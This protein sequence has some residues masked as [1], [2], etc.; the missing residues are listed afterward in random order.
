MIQLSGRFGVAWR[1]VLLEVEAAR[2][3]DVVD[4]RHGALQERQVMRR[5]RSW[6]WR[7]CR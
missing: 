5:G 3:I 7:P 2:W 1:D 6:S 4:G